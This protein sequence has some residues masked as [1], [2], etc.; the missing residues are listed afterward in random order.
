VH[1]DFVGFTSLDNVG[2]STNSVMFQEDTSNAKIWRWDLG[3]TWSVVA[4]VNSPA[5]ESSGIVD[6][7][8]WFGDGA[9]VL[10]VQVGTFESSE[11]QPDGTLLKRDNG[12][13][14]LMKIPGS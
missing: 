13:L 6:A 8:K 11:P 10:T 9:W 4:T 5:G 7:S 14:L 1:G 2:T 12:Q 3:S